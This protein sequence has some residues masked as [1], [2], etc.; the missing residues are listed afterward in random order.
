MRDETSRVLKWKEAIMSKSMGTKCDICK[1]LNQGVV[2]SPNRCIPCVNRDRKR[3]CR[4]CGD[5]MATDYYFHEYCRPD[6]EF[7]DII[8]SM[9]Y[10]DTR[11]SYKYE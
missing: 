6:T 11:G 10:N 4:R 8:Y 3:K 2:G 5:L 7:L 9:P 1:D